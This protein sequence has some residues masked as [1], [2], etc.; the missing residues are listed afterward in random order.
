MIRY[1][2]E[3]FPKNIRFLI[4]DECDINRQQLTEIFGDIKLHPVFHKGHSYLEVDLEKKT[5]RT[6]M[7]FE[8]LYRNTPPITTIEQMEKNN[9]I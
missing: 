8:W 9:E 6:C 5:W 1:K 2:E 7:D 3:I 4:D